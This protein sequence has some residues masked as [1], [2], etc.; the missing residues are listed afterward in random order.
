VGRPGRHRQPPGSSQRAGR[1]A[2]SIAAGGPVVRW[3]GHGETGSALVWIERSTLVH[4]NASRVIRAARR[5]R[6]GPFGGDHLVTDQPRLRAI[7][8]SGF[9]MR[10]GRFRAGPIRAGC[11]PRADEP[12]ERAVWGGQT[13]F[14]HA[15]RTRD[16]TGSAGSPRRGLQRASRERTGFT[17]RGKA[18]GRRAGIDCR[19]RGRRA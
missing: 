5:L 13:R 18:I 12:L 2:K 19:W 15:I 14:G 16:A 8:N 17:D 7:G 1:R 3:A 4:G 6:R 10:P 11:S 9:R